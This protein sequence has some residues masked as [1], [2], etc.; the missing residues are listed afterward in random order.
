MTSQIFYLKFLSQKFCLKYTTETN[1]RGDMKK[2]GGEIGKKG[3]GE[4]KVAKIQELG[5]KF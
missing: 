4:R 1:E 2:R 3:G 5:S